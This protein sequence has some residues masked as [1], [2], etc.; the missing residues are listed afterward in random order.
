MRKNLLSGVLFSE[1]SAG[2]RGTNGPKAERSSLRSV[3]SGL[4]RAAAPQPGPRTPPPDRTERPRD[5]AATTSSKG[6][7]DRRATPP[8]LRWRRCG[9][10]WSQFRFFGLASGSAVSRRPR[11]GPPERA[12][13]LRSP[14]FS[15]REAFAGGVSGAQ[16]TRRRKGSRPGKGA[17]AAV[18]CGAEED[19]AGREER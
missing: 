14:S 3:D 11:A 12:A 18:M 9:L 1:S 10:R 7:S 2:Q 19:G 15:R 8:V 4:K 6:I 16:W 17:D 5:G 13:A